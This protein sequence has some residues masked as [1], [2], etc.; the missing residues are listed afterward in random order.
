M[1]CIANLIL[2][3]AEKSNTIKKDSRMRAINFNHAAGIV[4]L[5]QALYGLSGCGLAHDT[6]M[7]VETIQWP[8]DNLYSSEFYATA[9]PE[10]VREAINGRS[11]AWESYTKQDVY[12]Y[13]SH[14]FDKTLSRTLGLF[15]PNTYIGKT[16]LTPLTVALRSTKNPEI[17]KTLL[18]A[19]ATVDEEA[20]SYLQRYDIISNRGIARLLLPY[21]PPAVMCESIHS[22]IVDGNRDMLEYCFTTFESASP[23]C[24][25]RY[26]GMTPFLLAAKGFNATK[27]HAE[28]VRYLLG[29]GA[30]IEKP[31]ASGNRPLYLA[32][33]YGR[34]ET[35]TILLD[36]G[37]EA[38]SGE[39]GKS[40]LY[41]A[42]FNGEVKDERLLRLLAARVPLSG[43]LKEQAALA[44]CYSG[45]V[46]TLSILLARG[47][48]LQ[49][50]TV[51]E[52]SE[53]VPGEEKMRAFLAAKGLKTTVED[54]DDN[55]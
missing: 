9:T 7:R 2:F 37:A 41:V 42:V 52:V 5:L 24:D 22:F 55:Q 51:Y 31:D 3:S 25:L 32:L 14:F 18:E 20:L 30:D 17:I 10:K 45:D 54:T 23:N 38:R 15:F 12:E 26:K 29:K 39:D 36:R 8:P 47:A 34:A 11:L 49:S 1:I 53:K 40:L 19:R 27:D 28:I 4:L 13:P 33:H 46:S 6:A 48:A 16:K 21:A 43:A 44:A 35:A 50:G